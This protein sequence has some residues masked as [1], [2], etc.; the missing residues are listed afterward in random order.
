MVKK[1]FEVNVNLNLKKCNLKLEDGS[2][3]PALQKNRVYLNNVR[4]HILRK[5]YMAFQELKEAKLIAS[6]DEHIENLL[7]I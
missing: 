5:H 2:D 3:C 4:Q 6:E 1:C 7:K